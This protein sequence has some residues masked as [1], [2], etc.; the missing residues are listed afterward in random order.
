MERSISNK[1]FARLAKQRMQGRIIAA[2]HLADIQEEIEKYHRDGLL[3]EELYSEYF[4]FTFDLP[5]NAQECRSIIVIAAPQPH[6]RITF[7]WNE[8][9]VQTVVPPTYLH[10]KEVYKEI[11]DDVAATLSAE[12]YHVFPSSLPEKT[13]ASHSGL[14]GYGKN[15]ISYV[16]GLG[17]YHQLVS[18]YSDLPPEEDGWSEA[19]MMEKCQKCTTCIRSCPT[20]AIPTDRFLLR[21]ERCITFLNERPGDF[22][23]W[24]DPSWHTCLIGCLE[25]QR[26]CPLNKEIEPGTFEI[27]AFS[28]EESELILSGVAL[29]RLP[30]EMVRKLKL[31]DMTRYFNVLPRN[32]GVLLKQ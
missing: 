22:P 21:A 29:D 5:E 18:F 14:G 32:L 20:G 12:G 15:N 19:Q 6:V 24:I 8:R 9:Q 28:Q 1:L 2:R 17:S 10:Y 7:T 3:D 25:C 26:V 30:D 16:P 11:R 13:L 4:R 31:A 27:A 23:E